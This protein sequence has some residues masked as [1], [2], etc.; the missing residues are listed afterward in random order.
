MF[1]LK[2]SAFVN[3]EALRDIA[4]IYLFQHPEKGGIIREGF[5]DDPGC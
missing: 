4:G 3:R 2:L 1:P 5:L